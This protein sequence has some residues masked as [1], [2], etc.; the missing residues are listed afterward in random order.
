MRV[1]LWGQKGGQGGTTHAATRCSDRRRC[2]GARGTSR[3]PGRRCLVQTVVFSPVPK[4]C[5]PSL[6]GLR[7][8]C[9]AQA[10]T[11]AKATGFNR[12]K[13]LDTKGSLKD[14]KCE[15]NEGR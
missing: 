4:A 2:R 15:I 13:S 5:L 12:I 6:L 3:T 9:K 10:R 11:E 7:G 8:R 14:G 1:I